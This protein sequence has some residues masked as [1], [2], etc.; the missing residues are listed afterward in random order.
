MSCEQ[1][2]ASFGLRLARNFRDHSALRDNY[3]LFGSGAL[4]NGLFFAAVPKGGRRF[5][6]FWIFFEVICFMKGY[7][8]TARMC[9]VEKSYFGLDFMVGQYVLKIA[10]MGA[11]I[12]VWRALYTQGADMGGMTLNQV[13][14]YTILSTFLGPVLNVQTPASSWLHDGTMLS[15]YQRPSTIF[16]QLIAHTMGGWLMPLGIMLVPMGLVAFFCGV[17]MRPVDGWF[18]VSI[19]LS[20]AQGFAV[21]FLFACLMIRMDGL[22]WPMYTLRNALTALFTGSVIPFAALP[23][24]IGRYLALSPLGTLA[25]APLSLY[26]GLGDPFEIILAQALW[27]AALWPLAVWCFRLSRERMVSYGG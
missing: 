17:D 23:W 27:T 2:H 6:L 13:L 19:A 20:I 3:A 26:S 5:A 4:I 18:A 10:A 22:E 16:G 7:L 11:L 14:V 24:G 9:L 15:L 21:D 12:M 8:A 25:G 1:D